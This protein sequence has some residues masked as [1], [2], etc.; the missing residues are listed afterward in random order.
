VGPNNN[1]NG[2]KGRSAGQP[3]FGLVQAKAWRLHS[4]IGSE[5]DPMSESW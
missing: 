5:E 1:S 3:D 2:L 4:H